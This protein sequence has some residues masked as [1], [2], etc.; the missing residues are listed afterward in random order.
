MGVG[1]R[2]FI[3]GGY[4]T[5]AD[6]ADLASGYDR[7]LVLSPRGGRSFHPGE[8]GTHLSTQIDAL[9]A[10]GSLVET[11][12][13]DAASLEAFGDNM[14][15]PATRVPAARAGFT[16]GSIWSLVNLN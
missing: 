4:R 3:D 13:P 16:R 7:V 12:F 9:R 6:N 5:N 2:R 10:Q 11:V 14:M 8:W 15:N 1:D